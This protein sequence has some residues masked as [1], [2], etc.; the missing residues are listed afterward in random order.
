MY[1]TFIITEPRMN[2]CLQKI[3][4]N[5]YSIIYSYLFMNFLTLA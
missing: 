1:A 2:P 5:N 3:E 4:H